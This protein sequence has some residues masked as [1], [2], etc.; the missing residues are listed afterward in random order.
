MGGFFE[1]CEFFFNTTFEVIYVQM[2]VLDVIWDSFM[3]L[4]DFPD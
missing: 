2:K 3:S 1:E 4:E